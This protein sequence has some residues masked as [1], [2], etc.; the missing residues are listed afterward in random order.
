LSVFARFFGPRAWE[1]RAVVIKD[2]AADPWTRGCPVGSMTPGTMI[3]FGPALREPC[4]RIHW[5]GTETARQWNGYMEGALEAGA[6][7]ATEVLVG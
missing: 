1:A 7:A 6:R 2:W 5:A 3:P 4:G